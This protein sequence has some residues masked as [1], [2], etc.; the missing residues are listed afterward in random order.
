M[1]IYE[2]AIKSNFFQVIPNPDDC[3]M[4]VILGPGVFRLMSQS[5][6]IWR[7]FGFSRADNVPLQ[8]ACWL[9]PQLVLAGSRD[10][11]IL[12]VNYGEL[13]NIYEADKLFE[14]EVTE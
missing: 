3:S 11:R 12:L 1:K 5:D 6:K 14:I 7:Q 4:F 13:R 2:K 8:V 9:G 10:G